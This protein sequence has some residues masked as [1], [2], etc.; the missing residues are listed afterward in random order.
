MTQ[1]VLA[2]DDSPDIHRILDVRLKPEGLVIH[3]ALDAD[4][5]VAMAKNLL[6]DLILLDVDMPLVTGFEV[7]KRIKDEPRLA[8]VPVVFLTGATETYAKVQGF[9]LGAVDYVTKPFEPAELRARVRAALRTKRYHDLLAARSN[10]DALTALWNRS[11]F[12]QR[13]GDEIAAVRRYGRVLSLV[14]LDLDHFKSKN[15]EFG[16]PF[17]DQILQR[18]GEVLHTTLRTTD[19]PCRYGGEEFALILSDTDEDGAIKA[20]ERVRE[21][22]G[23]IAFRPKDRPLRVTASLGVCCSSMLGKDID[24]TRMIVAADDALYAAKTSG[25]DRVSVAK[26]SGASTI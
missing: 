25:R 2:I 20:A 18:V 22:I 1:T 11:Y 3:H 8:Q 17:G 26:P 21:A 4:E 5:G 13:L 23:A 10:V 19:A 24:A 15:D 16:H 9:D 7:C 12:N 6:P 14:M